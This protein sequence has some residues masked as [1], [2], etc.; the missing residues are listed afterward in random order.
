MEWLFSSVSD[1]VLRE[2]DRQLQIAFPEGLPD[3]EDLV[4]AHIRWGDARQ[5][6][7]LVKMDKYVQGIRD[8]TKDR[9][10]TNPLHIY[11]STET[12]AAL[13]EFMEQKDEDW[14]V[15]TSNIMTPRNHTGTKAYSMADFAGGS[16]GLQSMGALL[17]SMEA[18]YYVLTTTSHWSRLINELRRGVVDT[19]CEQC[20]KLTDLQPAEW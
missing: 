17:M 11:V 3:S 2:A 19:R 16:V 20:T 5:K 9:Q 1:L 8:M 13:D 6:G 4:T 15:H 7:K 10:S 18:N 12:P 14:I